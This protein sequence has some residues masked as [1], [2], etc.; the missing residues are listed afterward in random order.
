MSK[1]RINLFNLFEFE[2]DN[3][4][5]LVEQA[6]SFDLVQYQKWIDT[7]ETNTKKSTSVTQE[8][9]LKFT[10]VLSATALYSSLIA[11]L[12]KEI[13]IN[14]GDGREKTYSDPLYKLINYEPNPW[15][16]AFTF[17]ELNTMRLLLWGNS[18]NIIT[19]S[20][21]R[22]VA[23]S[24]VHPNNV[25]LVVNGDLIY[26]ITNV[27][28]KTNGDYKPG[29]ILH[30]KDLSLD[31]VVG[32]SRIMLAKKAIGLGLAAEGF[33]AELFEKGG[34]QRGHYEYPAELGDQAFNRLKAQLNQEKNHGTPILEG[35]MK[36]TPSMIP[37]EAAQFIAS[38]EFQIQDVARIFH[39]PNHLVGDLSKATFSNIEHQDIT[40]V[41]Y[42]LRPMAKRMEHEIEYKLMTP[43]LGSKYTRFNL[44]GILRG[45]TKSRAEYLSKMVSSKIMNR[46][47]A[48]AIENLNPVEGGE[49]FENPNTS[50]N[51][52]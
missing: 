45:D 24:P 7:F 49:V 31:G 17:W 28:K 20:K 36:F 40:Y 33:G 50:K 21:G 8:S 25:E 34:I 41:K 22:V 12:P 16:N 44:E 1:F 51:E 10:A 30:F 9:S 4:P 15:M 47:E 23:L 27:D 18:Y 37:P 35:G 42:G 32:K 13:L 19:R 2:R 14:S 5:E 26:R 6:R 3:V 48:R 43:D 38:R 29:D 52:E 46:N 11:S 39:V